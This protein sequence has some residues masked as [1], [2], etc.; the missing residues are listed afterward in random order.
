VG[1]L[2]ADVRYPDY[3]GE[4]RCLTNDKA[5]ASVRAKENLVV[6]LLLKT[7]ID[8]L[9]G[10]RTRALMVRDMRIRRFQKDHLDDLFDVVRNDERGMAFLCKFAKEQHMEGDLLFFNDV[11][12]KFMLIHICMHEMYHQW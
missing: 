12:G 2:F 8:E 9:V 7:D 5:Y 6:Y 11:V 3:F 1:L 4:G 10:R